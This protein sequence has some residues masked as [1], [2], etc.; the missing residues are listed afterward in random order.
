MVFISQTALPKNEVTESFL[1]WDCE[2]YLFG[3]RIP[4]PDGYE[5]YRIVYRE[6]T[7]EAE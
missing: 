6:V 3:A 4:D 5:G 1:T 7:Q 2:V